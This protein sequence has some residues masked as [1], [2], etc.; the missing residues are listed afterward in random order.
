VTGTAAARRRD[1]ILLAAG[2]AIL[3][4]AALTL[5]LMGHPWICKCG[6]LKLW[7]AANTPENSQE[8]FDWYTP[9]HII[10]GILFYG[11]LWLVARRLPVGWRA[12]IALFV[13]TFWE[14]LENTPFIIDRYREATISLDYF[15]DSVVNSA[16]DILSMLAGFFLASRLPVRASVVIAVVL[17]LVAAYVIRD[18]L[19]LNIIMLL[20]PFD[21]IRVWQGGG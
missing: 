17:E 15:G 4:G 18:N 6:P 11:A 10:H 14:I 12:F 13:E 20:H 1:L 9:S 7:G 3:A 8:L 21:A 16:S 2:V 19:T 5:H